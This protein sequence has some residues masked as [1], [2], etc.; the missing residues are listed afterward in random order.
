MAPQGDLAGL[1]KLDAIVS[2]A[3]AGSSSDAAHSCTLPPAA[4]TS[5]EFYALEV[6][7]IFRKDW[8]CVGHVA[9]IANVGDYFTIDLFGELLVV[10]RGADRIRVMSRV[11][12]HRWAPVVEGAGNAKLFSCPFHKWG[13]GLDGQLLGAPFME[14][15][16]DFERH[17]CRLPEIR[18][19]IIDGL[20]LIFF[21]FSP[22]VG[23]ISTR[24]ASLV[25]HLAPANMQDMVCSS[26]SDVE[27]DYNWKILIETFM[28][29]YHHIGAHR[30]T[31]EPSFPARLSYVE[32]E[33]Q[34]WSLCHSP[35]REDLLDE[36]YS[37]TLTTP[38]SLYLIYPQV[39]MATAMD[40][41]KTK[42]VDV[43]SIIPLA[44][45]KVRSHRYTFIPKSLVTDEAFQAEMAMAKDL[46]GAV[47]I[48]D[49]E[50]N[51]MQQIG[52]ASSFA[53]IGRLSHL[54]NSVWHLAEYV[55]R[56]L[57]AD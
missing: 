44:A 47:N 56:C 27:N 49:N 9:Q 31:L 11:C 33:K 43:L 38:F 25:E 40:V 13:Y 48:E 55:R 15:V 36:A 57:K 19:E 10:V 53:P 20:G 16:G 45:N 3:L 50:V 12:L 26:V 4:Y 52:A 54:E 18:S 32:D 30:E 22:D 24:L 23:S 21:T 17:E 29:C 39:L 2:A 34:G 7:K 35:L 46:F 1:S 5:P 37:S 42:R 51:D 8:I 41:A 6:E 14:Q 28:E